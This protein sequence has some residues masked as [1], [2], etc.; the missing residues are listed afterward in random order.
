MQTIQSDSFGYNRLSQQLNIAASCG[1]RDENHR[2]KM[3]HSANASDRMDRS[4][5]SHMFDDPPNRGADV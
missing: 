4:A 3:A 5:L 2:P 1:V